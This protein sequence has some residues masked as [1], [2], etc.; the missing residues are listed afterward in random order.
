MVVENRK[1]DI[2]EM[3]KVKIIAMKEMEIYAEKVSSKI[4]QSKEVGK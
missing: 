2:E 3:E 4:R 1:K